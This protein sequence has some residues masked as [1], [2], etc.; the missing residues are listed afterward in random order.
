METELLAGISTAQRAAL[1]G[2]LRQVTGNLGL[3]L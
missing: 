2:T 3:T 1:T